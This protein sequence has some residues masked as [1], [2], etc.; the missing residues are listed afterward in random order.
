MTLFKPPD[1]FI[2][3]KP[4]EWPSWR[5]RFVRYRTAAKLTEED[6]TVK[7]STLIYAMGNKA[8]NINKSFVFNEREKEDDFETVLKKYDDYFVPQT[9]VIH[10][11]VQFHQ[12][13]QRPGEKAET[14]IR[15]LYELSENCD[16]G[17][18]RNENI[19]DRLVV[20]I[21]DKDLSKRLQLIKALTLDV[22]VQW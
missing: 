21:R 14:F 8:E 9:N 3:D 15:A 10:E 5:Q 7:V 12:R 11:R 13:T 20:G 2:F 4:G 19:R 1:N 16:F 22:A 17:A 6:G 18:N